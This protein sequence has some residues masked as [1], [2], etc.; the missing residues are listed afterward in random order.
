MK[1]PKDITAI[2]IS[3]NEISNIIYLK[4]DLNYINGYS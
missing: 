2:Q 1:K 3:E 4:Y